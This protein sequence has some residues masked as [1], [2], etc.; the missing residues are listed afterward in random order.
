M[1]HLQSKVRLGREFIHAR[2]SAQRQY[3]Y[4]AA[5]IASRDQEIGQHQALSVSALRAKIHKATRE[6][7][8][9]E[10]THGREAPR[11]RG[12]L[13]YFFFFSKL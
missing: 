9:R 2:G 12:I 4:R 13:N 8:A 11:L 6:S 7:Q 5:S 1:W 10:D 3:I